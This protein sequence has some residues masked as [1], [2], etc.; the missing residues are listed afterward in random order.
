MRYLPFLISILLLSACNEP[1]PAPETVQSLELQLDTISLEAKNDSGVVFFSFY[2]E[3]LQVKGEDSLYQNINKKIQQHLLEGNLSFAEN[4]Q[5]YQGLYDSI[6]MEYLRLSKSDF[7]PVSAWDLS[8]SVNIALN[9][10]G[11]FSYHSSHSAF[12]GGAHPNTFGGSQLIRL[13][14]GAEL[15]LDSI[16]KPGYSNDFLRLAESLFR[17]EYQ[18]P[19][20]GSLNEHGYWFDE[21]QFQLSEVFTYNHEGLHFHYNP[22]EIG[23]YA[24]G[25]LFVDIPYVYLLDFLKPEYQLT[26]VSEENPES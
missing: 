14:D 7:A 26:N 1:I 20:T 2:I 11:L 23:P 4:I 5:S 3:D 16:I 25:H 22:Y 13:K 24:M 15:N 17:K 21:D 6:R 8:Q 9:E 19:E 18:L 10:E 12:T